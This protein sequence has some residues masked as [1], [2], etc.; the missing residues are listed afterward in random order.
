MDIHP[1]AEGMVL[2]IPKEQIDH[3]ED[4]PDELLCAV[5]LTSKKIMR[6]L[7]RVYTDKVKIAVQI[8]GL[9][10]PHAHVKLFPI[11]S[12]ADFHA[13]PNDSEPDHEK[14]ATIAQKIKENL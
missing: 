12:G 13:L 14:L 3:F 10:V 9:E 7:R 5:M 8:E 4:L 1:I 6:A 11:N 2:V